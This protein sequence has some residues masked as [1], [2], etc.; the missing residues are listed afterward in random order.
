VWTLAAQEIG[1]V[2]SEL[3]LNWLGVAIG[4]C[5]IASDRINPSLL[6]TAMYS[7]TIGQ[8]LDLE[9][10]VQHTAGS[11]FSRYDIVSPNIDIVPSKVLRTDYDLSFWNL[12]TADATVLFSPWTSGFRFGIGATLQNRQYGSANTLQVPSNQPPST[13]YYGERLVLGGNL[14]ID[15]VVPLSKTLDIGLRTQA[16]ILLFRLTGDDSVKVF[17][18]GTASASV[19]FRVGF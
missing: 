5:G 1:S 8:G 4:V 18:D 15:Y 3:S 2:Q 7:R 13:Y 9:L 17:A 12:T 10:S 16:H 19:F 14:K 6:L 11:R